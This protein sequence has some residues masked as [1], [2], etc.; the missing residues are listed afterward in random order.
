MTNYD[1]IQP[2]SVRRGHAKNT[3]EANASMA[4]VTGPDGG[5]YARAEI[6]ERVGVQ[7]GHVGAM[8]SSLRKLRRPVTWDALR[9][10]ATRLHG[11]SAR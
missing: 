2:A 11:S 10:R 5:V 9:D 1:N 3:A 4:R 6:A 8:L 7:L